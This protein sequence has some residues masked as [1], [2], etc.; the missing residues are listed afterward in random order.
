MTFDS[1]QYIR[2]LRVIQWNRSQQ[3]WD[4]L[5]LSQEPGCDYSKGCRVFA[6]S[7]GTSYFAVAAAKQTSWLT[8]LKKDFLW[9]LIIAEAIFWAGVIFLV[10]WFVRRRKRKTIKKIIKKP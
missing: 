7:P 9:I 10:V 4:E 6:K 5:P 3:R 8:V 2:N 1:P